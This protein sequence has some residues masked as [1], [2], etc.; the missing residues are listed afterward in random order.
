MIPVASVLLIEDGF[1]EGAHIEEHTAR[2]DDAHWARFVRRM[3]SPQDF[4]NWWIARRW[5]KPRDITKE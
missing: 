3:P 5:V 2:L 1:L 4:L